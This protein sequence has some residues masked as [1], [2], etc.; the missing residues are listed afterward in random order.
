MG[1]MLFVLENWKMIIVSFYVSTVFV[2]LSSSLNPLLYLWRMK[3]IRN[4]VTKL[5]KQKLSCMEN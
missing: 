2:F 4:E 5:V 3:D 1:L